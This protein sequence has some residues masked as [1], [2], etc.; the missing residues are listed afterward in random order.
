MQT[1]TTMPNT[2]RTASVLPTV[3]LSLVPGDDNDHP[4]SQLEPPVEIAAPGDLASPP[5][6]AEIVLR[7]T[8]LDE[9]STAPTEAAAVK[10]VTDRLRAGYQKGSHSYLLERFNPEKD[11]D[12]LNPA[13][14]RAS[15]TSATHRHRWPT[16]GSLSRDRRRTGERRRPAGGW[17][18][19]LAARIAELVEDAHAARRDGSWKL[20][21]SLATAASALAPDNAEVRRL[22]TGPATRRQMTLLFCDLVGSTSLADTRDPEEITSM[23]E[24]YRSVCAEAVARYEGTIDDKRGDGMLVLFG[25]PQVHEDDARR[26]VLCGLQ[27]IRE[28]GTRLAS[29]ATDE[30]GQARPISVRVSV[31]T[32]LVVIG[33][34]IAGST[35]TKPPASR[36]S[37]RRTP[38]S[39]AT[40]R[41]RWSP[42]G[43]RPSSRAPTSC[44][45]WPGRW[46]SSVSSASCP[47]VSPR[48][49]GRRPS[50]DARTSWPRSPG[51]PVPARKAT[52]RTPYPMRCA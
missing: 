52:G 8:T 14:T 7:V 19:R 44:A 13:S 50:S 37:P 21:H 18:S 25:Y 24:A 42:R 46:A 11:P 26:A 40:R 41:T 12:G 35:A 36:S 48:A 6:L 30:P 33:D 47:T 49:S 29:I 34:G 20:A 39:S 1:F 4:Y 23:L 51:W 10:R 31:H 16:C 2:R 43:S 38:S 3:F 22:L 32:D 15:S 28:V 45:G 17:D 9:G 5:A 27:I